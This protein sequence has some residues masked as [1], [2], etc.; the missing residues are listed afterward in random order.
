MSD[1]AIKQKNGERQVIFFRIKQIIAS[2]ALLFCLPLT[3]VAQSPFEPVAQ[4][5]DRVITEWNIAQ[6][7]QFLELFGTPGDLR[8]AALERLIEEA[9]QM[10]AASDAGIIASNQV[11]LAGMEEFVARAELTVDEFLTIIGQAGVTETTFRDFVEAGLVWRELVQTRFGPSS[12]PT[13]EQLDTALLQTGTDAGA[14]VLLSEIILPATDPLTLASSEARALE[15]SEITDATEFRI[16]ARRFSVSSSRTNGGELDWRVLANLPEEIRAALEGL[17]P[18]QTTVPIAIGG[19]VTVLHLRD[20]EA[21]N[22]AGPDDIALEYV[23]ADLGSP[24]AVSRLAARVHSCDDLLASG[25]VSR[26]TGE[27]ISAS[28][29]QLPAP[30]A[31]TLASLDPGEAAALNGQPSTIVMLCTRRLDT[32]FPASRENV[33]QQ[34]IGREIARQAQRF[35]AELRAQ[36]E[37]KIFE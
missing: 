18:G 33:G 19:G 15:L 32:P 23:S 17:Q 14:R 4:V 25:V 28:R 22:A 37:I 24:A 16:A 35:L 9:L 31:A 11:V 1:E 13:P 36:A 2:S 12:R 26:D 27:P 10:D 8:E 20:R 34:L 6:R 5:N 3:A 29:A 21:L 30:L 7:A